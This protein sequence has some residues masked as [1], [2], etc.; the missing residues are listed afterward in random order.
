M[1]LLGV[2]ERWVWRG[3]TRGDDGASARAPPNGECGARAPI[4]WVLRT[5]VQYI[6]MSDTQTTPYI[7]MKALERMPVRSISAPNMMG[8][9]KPP[10]PPARPTMPL[11]VPMLCGY[12]SLMYLKVLALPKA[13]ATPSTAIRAV[14]A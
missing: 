7:S 4:T 6:Q 14:N 12:S 5:S 3:R 8:R 13:Q 2:D 9:M 10:K 1:P 11:I